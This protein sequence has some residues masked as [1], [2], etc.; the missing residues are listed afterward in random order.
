MCAFTICYTG[1]M[2]QQAENSGFKGPRAHRFCRFCFAGAK[3]DVTGDDASTAVLDIDTVTHGR[4]HLQTKQMHDMMERHLKTKS[5]QSQFGAQWGFNDAHPPL[6]AVSPALDLTLSR[7]PDA[8]HSEYKGIANLIQFLLRDGILTKTARLGYASVLRGWPF[9]PG[10]PQLQSPL[11]HL[12]SCSMSGH[13]RWLIIIPALLRDWLEEKQLMPRFV[14]QIQQHQPDASPVDIVVSTTAAIAKSNSVLM[15]RRISD[16]DR[17]DIRIVIR[18]AR[19]MFNQLNIYASQSVGSRAASVVSVQG[20]IAQTS[21]LEIAT[22]LMQSVQSSTSLIPCAPMLTSVFTTRRL[23]KSTVWS[24]TWTAW[25]VKPSTSKSIYITPP[26]NLVAACASLSRYVVS[27]S[28][29]GPVR[30]R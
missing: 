4:Y 16:A 12:A 2:P 27:N 24:R 29:V 14:A 7:P 28:S 18:R 15:G 11:H 1:D 19:S 9:P 3:P 21:A 13:A 17:K 5:D 10:A 22:I 6:Q 8:A 26:A 25:R 20:E 23:P 30:S